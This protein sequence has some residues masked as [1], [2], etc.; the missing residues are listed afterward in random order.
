MN[1]AF[2][3][4]AILGV[5]PAVI[6]TGL[7]VSLATFQSP[8]QDFDSA[9]AWDGNWANVTGLVNIPCTAPP[10]SPTEITATENLALAEIVAAE[11]HHVLLNAWY[12]QL[13]AGWRGDGTPAGAWRVLIDGFAYEVVG[14]E[15]DSQMQM[16]RVTARLA[17]L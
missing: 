7:L 15:S 4:N 8:S 3:E 9:G 12:P 13:D 16:T 6:A 5:M 11:W 1:Q 14:V 10:K 17:T 2:I